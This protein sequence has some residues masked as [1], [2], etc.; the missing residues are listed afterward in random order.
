MTLWQRLT[1]P[2]RRKPA[3]ITLIHQVGSDLHFIEK[4][5]VDEAVRILKQGKTRE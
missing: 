5:P 2:F 4:V 3:T 1:K